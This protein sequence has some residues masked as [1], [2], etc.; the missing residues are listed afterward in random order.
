MH[1]T[2]DGV[3]YICTFMV[4]GLRRDRFLKISLVSPFTVPTVNDNPLTYH[5]TL[6]IGK[7]IVSVKD[8]TQPIFD[9]VVSPMMLRTGI[10][11]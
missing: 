1:A 7:V 4:R 6:W 8:I 9:V 10:S 5:F 3:V 2:V 11:S